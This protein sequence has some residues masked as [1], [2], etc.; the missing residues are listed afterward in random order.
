MSELFATMPAANIIRAETSPADDVA[1]MDQIA[2][3]D[4]QAFTQLVDRYGQTLATT[5]ARLT[6]WNRDVDDIL[7]EVLITAWSKAGQFDGSGSL[8][9]W[10]KRIAINHCRNHFRLARSLQ[11]RIEGFAEWLGVRQIV[12]NKPRWHDVDSNER[13]RT[14][15][16]RL[17]TDD[18]TVLALYYLEEMPGEEIATLLQIS[19]EAV[20]VRM[21]RARKRLKRIL[22]D[23]PP[24]SF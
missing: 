5:I 19:V 4:E 14:A 20:H 2:T 18:R 22:K 15:L 21:H 9:G 24:G 1:L 11:R 7:Q 12:Q 16:S 8:E 23:E 13:V 6:G 10:L 17:S 3:G